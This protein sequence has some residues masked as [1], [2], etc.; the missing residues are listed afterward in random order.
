[1][2]SHEMREVEY[3]V[4]QNIDEFDSTQMI[5]AIRDKFF[6]VALIGY[7]VCYYIKAKNL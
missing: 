2:K 3:F 1:M 5:K 6:N 7:G 4:M